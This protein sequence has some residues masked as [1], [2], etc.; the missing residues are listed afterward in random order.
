MAPVIQAIQ[1]QQDFF[2]SV[3]CVTAQ[4][5]YMLDQVLDLFAI[6]PAYDLD[7]MRPDQSLAQLTAENSLCTLTMCLPGKNPNGVRPG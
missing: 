2:S 6:K 1:K 4:H 7:L 5:R 3:V